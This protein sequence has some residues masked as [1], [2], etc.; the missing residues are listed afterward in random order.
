MATMALPSSPPQ[1]I[2][3]NTLLT[4]QQIQ[5]QLSLLT[6]HEQQ[7][8]AKLQHLI[9]PATRQLRLVTQLRALD[10]LSQVVGGIQLEANQMRHKVADV[11]DTA[12]RVGGTVRQLDLEQASGIISYL[13][14][15]T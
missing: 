13:E 10:S 2:D 14:L 8:D 12:E 6:S 9:A 5:H 15:A 7:L 3:I 4:R 1:S 11:A